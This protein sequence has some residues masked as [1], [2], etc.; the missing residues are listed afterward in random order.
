MWLI[1]SVSYLIFLWFFLLTRWT[2]AMVMFSIFST[3]RC[4]M[5]DTAYMPTGLLVL[6]S[7]TFCWNL[8]I[9]NTIIMTMTLPVCR[10]HIAIDIN[11]TPALRK[12]KTCS[13]KVKMYSRGRRGR[14]RMVVGLTTTYAIGAYH[15]WCCEFKS[16]YFRGAQH[17]TFMAIVVRRYETMF[18]WKVIFLE[19]LFTRRSHILRRFVYPKKSY[20]SKVCLPEEEIWLPREIW[21]L[22]V[23]KVSYLPTTRAIHCLLYRNY[24]HSNN[25]FFY[26]RI[27]KGDNPLCT[28]CGWT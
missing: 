24:T 13:W 15:H 17:Y 22:R 25:D 16:R 23:N 19:G 8:T 5:I 4:L 2:R 27:A 3:Y 9:T 12:S 18:S 21:L 7:K 11:C 1:I 28:S 6:R 20:F 10:T 14:D 26:N